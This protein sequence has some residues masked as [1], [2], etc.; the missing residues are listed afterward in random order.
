MKK[1]YSFRDSSFSRMLELKKYKSLYD[2]SSLEV[3]FSILSTF[4]F[5]LLFPLISDYGEKISVLEKL[6]AF[7]DSIGMAM[8]GFLGVII[9]GLAISIAL[10]SNKVFN[11]I[12][13]NN[14]LNAIESLLYGFYL[15]GFITAVQIIIMV[16]LH[17]VS[18]TNIPITR[19]IF[20]IDEVIGS[21]LVYLFTFS[22]FYTVKLIGVGLQLFEILNEMENKLP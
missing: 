18:M 6:V 17:I 21:I 5:L 10:I 13:E 19:A 20:I 2:V 9:A 3:I 1:K 16:V 14:H 11:Y 8:I 12:K 7:Y 22:M 15:L 4:I